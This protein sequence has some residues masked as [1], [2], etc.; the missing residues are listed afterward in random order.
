MSQVQSWIILFV[1]LLAL[2]AFC[3]YIG[4]DD[5][6]YQFVDRK[7]TPREGLIR[8][9][10]VLLKTFTSLYG[11]VVLATA[12][13]SVLGNFFPISLSKNQAALVALACVVIAGLLIGVL[14]NQIRR[15]RGRPTRP[16]VDLSILKRN[17]RR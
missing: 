16:L 9:R 13:T 12:L 1:C 14:Q 3:S 7:P 17:L 5:V 6:V 11:G 2:T 15:L 4:D 10:W 8:I